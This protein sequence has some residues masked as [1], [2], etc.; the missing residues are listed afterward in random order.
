MVDKHITEDIVVPIGNPSS[1]GNFTPTDVDYNIAINGQPFFIANTD[2]R[3]YRRVTAKYRKDQVDQTTEPGEQTLTG[4]WIRSQSSFHLGSGIKY[5]EP[6]QEET[7]RY[8]FADSKGVDVWTQG[9]VTLLRDVETGHVMTG[10]IK[11][12]GRAQQQMRSIQWKT[13]DITYQGALVYDE[14]DIDKVF[15]AITASVSNKALTSNVATLTTSAAH[16]FCTGMEVTITGVDAT[17]NGTYTITGV[18][19]TT[20]FT[21]AKTAGNVASTAVSPVGI[22]T[23]NVIHFVDYNSGTDSPVF[24]MC[25]DGTTAYWVTNAIDT[26]NKLHVYKK[27]LNVGAS[28]APDNMFKQ[29]GI[30]VTNA[31]MEYVKDR[32]VMA[33][34]DKIYEFAPT[35]SALPAA[36]Y[37]HPNTNHIFTSITASGSAIYVAGYTGIQSNILKFTLSTAGVMPTLTSAVIAAEMPPGEV[38]HKIFYYL[39][40]MMIG[41]SKGIRA[42]VV[43]DNDG[44]INYGPLIVETDQPCYDF[45]ARGSYVWCATSVDGEPGVIRID[46]GISISPLRF[47]W[48]NDIYKSGVTGKPTTSCAFMGSTDRLGFSAAGNGSDGNIYIEKATEKISSGYLT[49]GRIRYNT[50]EPKLYKLLRAIIDLT[51]GSLNIYTINAVGTESG[52]GTWSQ[53]STVDESST[54]YPTG[55]QEYLSYKFVLNRS[56][57]DTSQGPVFSGYQV[58]A[59]PA[60][61]RQRIIQFPV[62]CYDQEADSLGNQI[63]YEDRSYDRIKL[64][65]GIEANGDTVRVQDFRT[66]ETFIA[67]I[68]ELDFMSMTPPGPRFN[69]FGGL[70]TITLRTV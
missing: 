17:F 25:D 15:P 39:G 69:G 51:Y 43:D 1:Q 10:G 18:P 60:T 54:P 19:T 28:T 64:L 36:V 8:R 61:P 4:W 63:G 46:L 21:Y 53:G 6:A 42:A 48:A 9:Q 13:N 50:L 66:D 35:A 65:E 49:T 55:P 62:Y 24:A 30:V 23:S 57:T 47:P 31:A 40:Y 16:G 20:T 26:D 56:S 70:L 52:A 44:S 38:I 37:T 5:F 68:E 32:I 29:N 12:N 14:Y 58:K 27:S 41:T 7:L 22:A 3:P 2:E 11:D 59:L 33:A 67:T 45:A 34:N